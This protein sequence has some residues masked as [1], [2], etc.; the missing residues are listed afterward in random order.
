MFTNSWF[1]MTG[2]A[3]FEKYVLPL[4]ETAT[5][6]LEV[7]C[8]EGQASKW[9]LE[10]SNAVLTVV[11]TFK[12]GEDLPDEVD[13]LERFKENTKE[14]ENR[15]AIIQGRSE[16]CLKILSPILNNNFDF[17]YI[18][19]SHLAKNAL[20]DGILAFPLLKKGGIMIFDDYTWGQGM[21]LLDIPKTGIDSF[22][23]LYGRELKVLEK[24]SQ[25]II[26]KN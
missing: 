5:T 21:D 20:E 2:K 10:N 19:G 24:N 18:D 1:E 6:F 17:I 15:I 23:F 3:N 8:Y 7:G 13:L 25:V 12:G 11:D 26:Q 22:I 14:F 9:M 16:D 4:K